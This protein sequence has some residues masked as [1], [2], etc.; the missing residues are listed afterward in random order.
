MSGFYGDAAGPDLMTWWGMNN[1]FDVRKFHGDATGLD[2]DDYD[3]EFIGMK[4]YGANK[5][6]E[7]VRNHCHF[8]EKYRAAAHSI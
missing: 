2:Y 3:D 7:R 1:E 6:Y 4:F 8:T 5:S